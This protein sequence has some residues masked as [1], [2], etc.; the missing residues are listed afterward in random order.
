MAWVM[1]Q[2][3][4]LKAQVHPGSDM[5]YFFSLTDY[6]NGLRVVDLFNVLDLPYPCMNKNISIEVPNVMC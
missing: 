4:P 3:P 6:T 5:G 2:Q 1:H